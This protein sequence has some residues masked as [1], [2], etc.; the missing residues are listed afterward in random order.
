[1]ASIL[2]V[3]DEDSLRNLYLMIFSS[4]GHW[5]V[6]CEKAEDVDSALADF[7]PDAAIIDIMLT[8]EENGVSLA[9]KL[10]QRFK[11]TMIVVVSGFLEKWDKADI[12]D[13]GAN[14]IM[15]KPFR[16]IE[17]AKTVEA[18]LAGGAAQPIDSD[19]KLT[20]S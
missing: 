20:Q 14:L 17:L 10:R 16:M 7:I 4:R 8:G 12:V 18:Y 9:W 3:E 1:M 19:S 15:R 11:H 6:A 2:I 5:C 13:C